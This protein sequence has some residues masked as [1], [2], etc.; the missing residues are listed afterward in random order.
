[1]NKLLKRIKKWFVYNGRTL[2]MLLLMSVTI[3]LGVWYAIANNEE[4]EVEDFGGAA[5]SV[6]AQDIS[7]LSYADAVELIN[8]GEEDKGL[9]VMM[10]LAPLSQATKGYSGNGDAHLWIAR[11]LL[12][13]Q[14]FGFTGKFPVGCVG[15]GALELDFELPASKIV[16]RAVGHL[17]ATVAL[18]TSNLEA[19]AILAEVMIAEGKRNDATFTLIK[20][21]ARNDGE[22]LDLGLNVANALAY[23]G[24]DLEFEEA[25]WHEFATLG[26]VIA[27]DG[28]G[29]ISLRIEYLLNAFVLQQEELASVGIKKFARDFD[30]RANTV[31]QVASLKALQAY[32]RAIHHAKSGDLEKVVTF[33]IQAQQHQP[34]RVEFVSALQALVDKFPEALPDLKAGL[35]SSLS[36]PA[37]TDSFVASRF[38]LLK[39]CVFPEVAS[40]HL[41]QALLVGA[42]DPLIALAVVADKR[43]TAEEDSAVLIEIIDDALSSKRGA[44]ENLYRL[45]QAKGEIALAAERWQEAVISLERALHMK[46]KGERAQS[47]HAQLAECYKTLGVDVLSEEHLALSK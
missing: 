44:R 2:M 27:A 46:P 6:V 47:L 23:E 24:D 35:K 33:L 41:E 28:R 22:L 38:S 16:E 37:I 26:Q 14:D 11:D 3:G 31:D 18:Q 43:F 20:T 25:I 1:M 19:A 45:Y 15:G 5:L 39:A 8:S 40:E 32:F 10:R 7:N 17:K 34:N 12:G 30:D 13:D 4:I 42:G 29:N 9:S 36:D 21:A